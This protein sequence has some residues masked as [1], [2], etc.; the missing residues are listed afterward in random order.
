MPKQ[1]VVWAKEKDKNGTTPG[2]VIEV[3]IS[4]QIYQLTKNN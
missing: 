2:T 4:R 3:T 1:L